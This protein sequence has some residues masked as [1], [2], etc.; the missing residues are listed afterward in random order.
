MIVPYDNNLSVRMQ[1]PVQQNS[2][3]RYTYGDAFAGAGGSSAGAR[4][5]GLD[6]KWAFDADPA[7]CEVYSQN[8]PYTDVFVASVDKFLGLK[9][10]G[11]ID[12]LLTLTTLSNVEP[13]SYSRWA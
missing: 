5:A 3:R 10:L 8:F 12:V 4:M 6:I 2:G 1:S 13:R 11:N 9:S 7:A